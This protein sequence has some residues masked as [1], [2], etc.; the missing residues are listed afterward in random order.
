M[1]IDLPL[2]DRLTSP[3]EVCVTIPLS[4]E[5]VWDI[6]ADPRTYPDWLAGAQRIRHVDSQFP[7]AGT[8]FDHEVGPA[9]E[10]TVADDTKSLGAHRPDRL[11]LEVHAGPMQGVVEFHL[12]ATSGGT[13][14]RMR[15]APIG[16]FR[17]AMPLI[18]PVLYL[19]N[20]GSL[21]RLRAKYAEA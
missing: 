2:A 5:A 21:A 16:A 20:K 13:E 18:R 19:R 8:K 14:V 7:Q 4:P 6:L 9:E 12:A 1:T 3:S 15:E 11:D 10:V 17:A